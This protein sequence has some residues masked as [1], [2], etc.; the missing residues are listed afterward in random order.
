[1]LGP[2][3]PFGLGKLAIRVN[4]VA[5]ALEERLPAR[6][7]GRAG[8]TLLGPAGVG[9]HAGAQNALFWRK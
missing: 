5:E 7:R 3:D 8:V 6:L 2:A 4:L 9:R 1:M